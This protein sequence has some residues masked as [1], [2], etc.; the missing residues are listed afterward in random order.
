[1]KIYVVTQGEYSDYHI[2]TATLSKRRAEEI[3]KRFSNDYYGSVP[4]IE[5]FEDSDVFLRPCWCVYFQSDGEIV[6]VRKASEHY[7]YEKI[8]KYQQYRDGSGAINLIADDEK[9]AVKIASEKRA[10]YLARREGI[11]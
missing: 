3:A 2:I 11:A 9:T 8:G 10:E 1:M 4:E 5:E 6:Y 7:D